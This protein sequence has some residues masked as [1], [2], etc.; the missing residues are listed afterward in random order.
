MAYNN[1]TI[2]ELFDDH[3]SSLL[4]SG[5]LIGSSIA[6]DKQW[7][8]VISLLSSNYKFSITRDAFAGTF[9]DEM[10]PKPL[11]SC[12]ISTKDSIQYYVTYDGIHNQDAA[13]FKM[14]SIS[15]S[16]DREFNGSLYKEISHKL[17]YTSTKMD[18][19]HVGIIIIPKDI[20]TKEF[21]TLW[22][23]LYSYTKNKH[24]LK[25]YISFMENM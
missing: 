25:Q 11:A 24:T 10:I 21:K 18:K 7:A 16:I 8:S 3:K 23:R 5:L 2:K 17:I 22:N 1:L 14:L 12:G 6:T 13:V 15:N 20:H 4:L 9:Y 19:A